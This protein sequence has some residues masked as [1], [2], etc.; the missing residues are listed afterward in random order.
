MDRILTALRQ[1]EQEP[2]EKRA[3]LLTPTGGY[4]L[5]DQRFCGISEYELSLAGK[6]L[7]VQGSSVPCGVFLGVVGNTLQWAATNTDHFQPDRLSLIFHIA[8]DEERELLRGILFARCQTA[9]LSL[10]TD[11][12]MEE[13]YR[14]VSIPTSESTPENVISEDL[15][16]YAQDCARRDLHKLT[17]LYL[18]GGKL[19][20]LKREWRQEND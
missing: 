14:A 2:R 18:H 19:S 6:E 4:Y 11:P 5:F 1:Y 20:Q 9:Y 16:A 3:V 10:F 17:A 7:Y 13:L 12:D 15:S 8:L